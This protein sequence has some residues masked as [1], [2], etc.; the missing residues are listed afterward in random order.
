MNTYYSVRTGSVK[1]C[2]IGYGNPWIK[3]KERK[4]FNILG[5]AR[6][7]EQYLKFVKGYKFIRIVK[8]EKEHAE[9]IM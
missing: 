9:T 1:Y 5:D 6:W 7:Y 2:F 4:T 3:W 8:V